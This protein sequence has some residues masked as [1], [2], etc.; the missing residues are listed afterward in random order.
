LAG[1]QL[2]SHSAYAAE[3]IL[4]AGIGWCAL[5]SCYWF[6]GRAGVGIRWHF[7]G[8]IDPARLAAV[9]FALMLIGL[10]NDLVRLGVS[11]PTVVGEVS[12]SWRSWGV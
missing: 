5:L 4:L 9:V 1:I 6:A 2:D 8:Q 3:D 12:G 11:V 7:R 10:A